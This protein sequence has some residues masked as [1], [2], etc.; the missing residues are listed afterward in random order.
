MNNVISV[1]ELR[2]RFLIALA[3]LGGLGSLFN[4]VTRLLTEQLK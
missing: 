3:L 4:I 2:S 1:I